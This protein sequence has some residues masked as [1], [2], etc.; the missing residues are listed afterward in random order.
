MYQSFIH[1]LTYRKQYDK[2]M[3]LREKKSVHVLI[4]T[5][6]SLTLQTNVMGKIAALFE[7]LL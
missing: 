3:L 5:Y 6:T 4:L 2:Q 7:R 1:D